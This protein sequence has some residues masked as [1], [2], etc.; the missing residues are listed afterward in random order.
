MTPSQTVLRN[1]TL[2]ILEETKNGSQSKISGSSDHLHSSEVCQSCSELNYC[3][4]DCSNKKQFEDAIRAGVYTKWWRKIPPV[5]GHSH[6]ENLQSTNWNSLRFKPPPS[7]ES[8]IGWRV[9]FRPMDIQLTDFENSALTIF[10]G[11][12]ANIVNHFDVDFV[13]PITLVDENMKRAHIRD[14]ILNEKFWW[15]ASGVKRDKD[16]NMLRANLE[17]NGFV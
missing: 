3:E 1:L 15:K 12:V 2:L 6:F 9:E 14:A 5:D 7:A 10:V 4:F 17:E 16:G 11:M 8:S 13:L